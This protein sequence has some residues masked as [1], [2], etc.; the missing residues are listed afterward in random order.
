MNGSWSLTPTAPRIS[1]SPRPAGKFWPYT[2]VADPNHP[3]YAGQLSLEEAARIIMRARGRTGLNRDYLIE[4]LRRIEAE[5]FADQRMHELLQR[6]EH[7]T[8]LLEAGGGI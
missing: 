8:G 5:G 3:Q 4:T 1:R 2:F 6:I 7:L